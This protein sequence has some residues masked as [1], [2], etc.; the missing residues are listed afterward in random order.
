MAHA[1]MHAPKDRQTDTHTLP[2]IYRL[3]KF[4]MPFSDISHFTAFTLLTLFVKD[5]PGNTKGGSI[6][7]LLT[8]C[9]TGL[10]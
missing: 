8:S 3:V 9:L 10:D 4:L 6:T 2:S 7:V 1:S 5:K